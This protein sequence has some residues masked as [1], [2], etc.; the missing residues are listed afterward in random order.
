MQSAAEAR[1][2]ALSVSNRWINHSFAEKLWKKG[3]A[4]VSMRSR[5]FTKNRSSS[6]KALI[7]MAPAI[8]SARW[9]ATKDLVV[10]FILINSFA[11]EK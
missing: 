7:V 11:V 4:L 10:P 9:F 1:T 3:L 5:F 6:S 2:V 8:D